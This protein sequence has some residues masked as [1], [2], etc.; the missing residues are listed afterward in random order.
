VLL[1]SDGVWNYLPDVED[2]A[3]F[4]IGVEATAAAH[5]LVEHALQAGGHDNI[6]VAVIPIGV[7]HEFS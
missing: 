4:C 2:V 3:R 1:C 5:A 7:L 6:T